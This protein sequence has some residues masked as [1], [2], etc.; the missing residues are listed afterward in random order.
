MSKSGKEDDLITK[1]E[2][3]DL[4]SI[5]IEQIESTKVQD[6]IINFLNGQPQVVRIFQTVTITFYK[7]YLNY[8]Y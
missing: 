1:E 2:F 6:Q 8:N 4:L 3:T 5:L 7:L